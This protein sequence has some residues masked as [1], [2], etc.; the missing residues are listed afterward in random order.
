MI[1]SLDVIHTWSPQQIGDQAYLLG[2]LKTKGF[3]IEKGFILLPEWFLK[4]NE[5]LLLKSLEHTSSYRIGV[6]YIRHASGDLV[7]F[8]GVTTSYDQVVTTVIRLY[9]M[10]G[11]DLACLIIQEVT[12]FER[13]GACDTQNPITN[14]PHEILVHLKDVQPGH[15]PAHLIYNKTNLS[16]I[17]GQPLKPLSDQQAFHLLGTLL[18]VEAFAKQALHMTWGLVG[19]RVTLCTCQPLHDAWLIPNSKLPGDRVYL[20]LGGVF[21]SVLPMTY[22]GGEMLLSLSKGLFGPSI[23]PYLHM[24]GQTLWLDVTRLVLLKKRPYGLLRNLLQVHDHALVESIDCLRT[25]DKRRLSFPIH[26]WRTFLSEYFKATKL[27]KKDHL[28]SAGLKETLKQVSDQQK[29][30]SSLEDLLQK[31]LTLLRDL[32]EPFLAV[33]LASHI[34]KKRLCKR[35]K[36]Y[37]LDT[38]ETQ[39]L[40]RAMVGPQT[41]E[42]HLLY[43]DLIKYKGTALGH[44]LED[45]YIRLYGLNTPCG[46]DI[47]CQIKLRTFEEALEREVAGKPIHPAESR[48]EAFRNFQIQADALEKNLKE[49]LSKRRWRLFKKHLETLRDLKKTLMMPIEYLLN[50]L[51]H[52]RNW[53][54]DPLMTLPE[55]ASGFDHDQVLFFRKLMYEHMNK[56]EKALLMTSEGVIL[57]KNTTTS[58]RPNEKGIDD[59]PSSKTNHHKDNPRQG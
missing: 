20:S 56:G 35:A 2:V 28:E 50:I 8:E 10:V 27:M 52:Y 19:N 54:D 47:G 49:R 33:Y 16:L 12:D 7:P 55:S 9:Q 53:V 29:A 17:S 3:P 32:F 36:W 14:N 26:F 23:E 11:E 58:L 45:R 18:E 5:G 30:I 21:P 39:T 37:G 22:V 34:Q 25:K 24:T 41:T 43:G 1:Y 44:E 57:Y 40:L 6:S 4:P 46:L 48:R 51:D 31:R 13:F 42:R 15:E 59:D 38:H